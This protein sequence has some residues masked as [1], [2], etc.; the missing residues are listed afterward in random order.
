MQHVPKYE[1]LSSDCILEWVWKVPQGVSCSR[2]W[3]SF[4][5]PCYW[6]QNVVFCKFQG[7]LVKQAGRSSWGEM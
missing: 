7:L 4:L 5:K 2:P 3:V 1:M 6:V